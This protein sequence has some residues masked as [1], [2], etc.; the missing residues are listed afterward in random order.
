VGAGGGSI[1]IGR[2]R[3]GDKK[4]AAREAATALGLAIGKPLAN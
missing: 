4:L 1:A 3:V 2:L